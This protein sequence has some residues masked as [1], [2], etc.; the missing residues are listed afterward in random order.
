MR[1]PLSQHLF[2]HKKFV[3][4]KKL[5]SF[6][7]YTP[8]TSITCKPRLTLL[9]VSIMT[10]FNHENLLQKI[11]EQNEIIKNYAAQIEALEIENSSLQQENKLLQT[12]PDEL[13]VKEF[14]LNDMKDELENALDMVSVYERQTLP[15]VVSEISQPE[16]TEETYDENEDISE[17]K[18]KR[19]RILHKE[20]QELIDYNDC[21][22]GFDFY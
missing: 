2:F 11:A 10:S 5:K 4:S 16:E 6:S 1:L 17:E 8:D 7:L 15:D 19:Y 22:G 13:R 12:L 18:M 9:L 14:E 21:C 3:N 20:L